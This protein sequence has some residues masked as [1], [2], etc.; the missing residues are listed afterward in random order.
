MTKIKRSKGDSNPAEIYNSKGSP[1]I[2]QSVV[3]THNS[4]QNFTHRSEDGDKIK[5]GQQSH[6][7]LI[8]IDQLNRASEDEHSKEIDRQTKTQY[9]I[10]DHSASNLS[11]S[12]LKTVYKSDLLQRSTE[13]QKDSNFVF[14]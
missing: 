1:K 2:I 11:K 12:K 7:H 14:K 9:L 13:T 8:C 4:T 3:E 10:D 5:S 6:S